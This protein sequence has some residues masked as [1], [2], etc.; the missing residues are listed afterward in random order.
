MRQLM[1]QTVDEIPI[2]IALCIIS[3]YEDHYG[4]HSDELTEITAEYKQELLSRNL[5][6]LE[7]T[8]LGFVAELSDI[9]YRKREPLLKFLV[10]SFSYFSKQFAKNPENIDLHWK[11]INKE[12]NAF[13]EI[14]FSILEKKAPTYIKISEN[15]FANLTDNSSAT[16]L[17]SCLYIES[18]HSRWSMIGLSIQYSLLRPVQQTAE[19]KNINRDAFIRRFQSLC[20]EKARLQH[21]E[22]ASDKKINDL[23]Q[24][25]DGALKEMH[26]L[27]T[28]VLELEQKIQLVEK[29]RNDLLSQRDER[30]PASIGGNLIDG[31][32]R[33]NPRDP[34]WNFPGASYGNFSA[35]GTPKK[36][37]KN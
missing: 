26:S 6:D 4:E 33:H 20:T 27:S 34:H 28:K 7:E 21:K 23:E 12:I 2:A 17:E 22:Q 3:Y 37:G 18:Q 36:P 10:N 19:C 8:L 14:L 1:F 29:E 31:F 35:F 32:R 13:Y 5:E 25:Y 30:A 24:K 16:K 15:G 11:T 9:G